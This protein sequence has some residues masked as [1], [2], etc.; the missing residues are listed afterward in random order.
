V[1]RYDPEYEASRKDRVEETYVRREGSE[2]ADFQR[3]WFYKY[4]RLTGTEYV[5]TPYDNKVLS[6]AA[7]QGMLGKI[8]LVEFVKAAIPFLM[9]QRRKLSIANAIDNYN[10][11]ILATK[12]GDGMDQSPYP[13]A[14]ETQDYLKEFRGEGEANGAPSR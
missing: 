4:G 14:R 2:F 13:T 10:S 11:I 12:S 6:G 1:S 5:A 9:S 7:A 8:D 3:L